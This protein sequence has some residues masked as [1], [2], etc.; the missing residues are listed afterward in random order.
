MAV[1]LGF[2]FETVDD[3]DS[4]LNLMKAVLGFFGM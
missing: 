4:R 2:P 1:V 3:P